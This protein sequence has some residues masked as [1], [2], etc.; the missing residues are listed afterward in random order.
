MNTISVIIPIYNVEAYLSQCL[1]SVI[2]QSYENLEIILVND[3]STDAC[4]Q[5]CEK[6]AA[7]DNRIKVIHQKNGGLSDA[8][9]TGLEIATGDFIAFVD[10]DDLVSTDFF[11][12][13]LDALQSNQAEIVE[14]EFYKFGTITDV[15]KASSNKNSVE[16][17]QTEMALELLMKEK[18][19]Q[20]VW[21][22]L[23]RKIAIGDNR[24]PVSKINE[25]EFWTYKVFGNAQ[26]IVKIADVLY[27][28]RQQQESIMGRKY[29]LKR[30][31][32][33][34]ALQER[35]AY[36]RENFPRLENLAIKSYCTA[37]MWHYQQI[38]SFMEVDPTKNH[39]KMIFDSI[40]Q[41][42]KWLVFKEWSWKEKLRYYLFIWNPIIYVKF[43]DTLETRAKRNNL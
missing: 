42:N 24:F 14:C 16:I 6:Y 17:F 32:G 13:L 1:D 40:K 7:K 35:I 11:Q 27:F 30:L 22:K 25:D 15:P 20:M 26:K 5:I 37:A 34:Q 36:M 23:Y 3:G 33:L 31:D 21:N 8:R 2:H 10:S 12:L 18:L 39:R 28:Y 41:Y 38:I 9:N 29:S 43:R 19:K 4:H